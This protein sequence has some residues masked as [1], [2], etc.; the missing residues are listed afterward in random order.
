M[1]SKEVIYHYNKCY[2]NNAALLI[3]FWLTDQALLDAVCCETSQLLILLNT[4]NPISIKKRS[5]AYQEV[6]SD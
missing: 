4:Y 2:S 1:F 6:E 5:E 3:V